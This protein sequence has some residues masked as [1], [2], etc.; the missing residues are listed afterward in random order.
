MSKWAPYIGITGFMTEK[1]GD[2]VL[3]V[4]PPDSKQK[5]MRGVL[6]SQKTMR[7]E[8]NKRPNRYPKSEDI[9]GIFTDHPL[10]LN[11]VHYNTNEHETLYGQMMDVTKIAGQNLHGFQLNL[12]WPDPQVLRH[13][14][15]AYPEMKIVL[16]VG[17]HAFELVGNSPEKLA[18]K[19]EEYYDCI[20]CIL[21]DPS[22]GNGVP[23]YP[24]IAKKYLD[25]LARE[26]FRFGF[27]VAGGLS[28]T[29][30]GLVEPLAYY[31]PDICIDAEGRLRDRNDCLDINQAKMYFVRAWAML[32]NPQYTCQNAR[33]DI[34]TFFS[35]KSRDESTEAMVRIF[36]H[37][38]SGGNGAPCLEC[39]ICYFERF[40]TIKDR[41]FRKLQGEDE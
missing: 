19:L 12:A 22:G 17:H 27:G 37:L 15:R 14:R 6:V 29:T 11:L 25:A 10:A 30:L 39:E 41:F 26:K 5:L 20:D 32:R 18:E 2:M 33:W 38:Q 31:F 21:L 9:A 1:E 13:Y 8:P 23:F 34:D 40:Q 28:P 16:Q 7:G 24:A 4:I 3:S 36:P 35:A